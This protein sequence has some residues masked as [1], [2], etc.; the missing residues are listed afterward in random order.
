MAQQLRAG[1]IARRELAGR[2]VD[3]MTL[4]K[5]PCPAADGMAVD[6]HPHSAEISPER[7]FHLL[8]HGIGQRRAVAVVGMNVCMSAVRRTV[9]VMCHDATSGNG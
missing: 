9:F 4:R 1:L 2:K 5:S 8:S 3:L 6:M 7:G